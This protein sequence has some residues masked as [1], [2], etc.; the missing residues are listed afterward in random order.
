MKNTELWAYDALKQKAEDLVREKI[1][2]SRKGLLNEPNYLHSFRVRDIVMHCHHWDD[3]DYDL[4]L[5]ALLH[6]VVEDCY[7]DENKWQGYTDIKELFGKEVADIV[8]ELTSDEDEMKH[9]WGG[10][11][12][13]YL[14]NK[15]L[16]MSDKAFTIKLSD[17]FNNI[18]DAFTASERFRNNYYRETCAIVDA[19]EE[20][21]TFTRVQR[22]LLDDIK[23]KLDNIKKIFKVKRVN[24]I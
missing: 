6:D 20:G 21:R 18:A 10:N 22:Q 9:K 4:F 14:I 15:M 12:A 7:E 2:G 13:N 1:K 11:K 5:A 8:W 17:R 23:A 24:E 3:G 19:M 16:K